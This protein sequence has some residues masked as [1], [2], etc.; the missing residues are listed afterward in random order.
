MSLAADLPDPGGCNRFDPVASRPSD[1]NATDPD[2][3]GM[4]GQSVQ[5][6]AV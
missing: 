5:K 4:A 3:A 6:L 1:A 2:L